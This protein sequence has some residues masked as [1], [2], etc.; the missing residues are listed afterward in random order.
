MTTNYRRRTLYSQLT[1]TIIFLHLSCLTGPAV[2]YSQ[3]EASTPK[4]PPLVGQHT[5]DVLKTALGY[6]G[7][8]IQEL[9][10]SKV[11]TQ[12]ELT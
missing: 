2:R 8:T 12:H 7:D 1:L 6:D 3:F 9:L 5:V 4:P 10:S 11:I